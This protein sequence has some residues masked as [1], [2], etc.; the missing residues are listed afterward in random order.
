MNGELD[1]QLRLFLHDS[2]KSYEELEVL[3]FLARN[4]ERTF[5][6]QAVAVA[7]NATARSLDAALDELA[8][9]GGLLDVIQGSAGPLYRYVPRD[10]VIRQRV[11][12]LAAAYADRRMSVVQML[13]ANALER[14]RRA[15]MRRLA[16]AFRLERGKK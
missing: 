7:L 4:E 2:V 13:S 12:E 1:E 16:D 5:S 14:V 6:A 8:S 10:E 9:V 3:L 15:A 11:A